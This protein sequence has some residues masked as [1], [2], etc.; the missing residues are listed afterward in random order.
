MR[1]ADIKPKRD[2]QVVAPRAFVRGRQV[3]WAQAEAR[4]RRLGGLI[5]TRVRTCWRN[6]D[7][8]SAR[9]ALRKERLN[10]VRQKALRSNPVR[11][12]EASE[13]PLI[14]GPTVY[15]NRLIDRTA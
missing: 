12:F 6:T 9:A 10:G 1:Q 5:R 4:R 15:L 2:P 11:A 14:V 8:K 13:C 3:I 7:N